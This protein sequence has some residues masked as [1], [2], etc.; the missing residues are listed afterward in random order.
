MIKLN[1]I[2]QKMNKIMN[3]KKTKLFMGNNKGSYYIE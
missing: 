1:Q 2:L 3:T